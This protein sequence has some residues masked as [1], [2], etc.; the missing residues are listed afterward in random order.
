ME[1]KLER[2]ITQKWIAIF[3]DGTEAWSTF[4]RTGYPK[5][6]PVAL[7]NSG[8]TISTVIQIRGMNYPRSEY[9]SNPTEVAKGVTLL[10]GRIMEVPG[11]GGILT[12]EIFKTVEKL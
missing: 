3:P 4:R 5:L 9:F 2:I 12:K 7:N 8:G 1:Q 10:G 6:F 11:C